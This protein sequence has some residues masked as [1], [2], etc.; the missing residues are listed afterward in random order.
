MLTMT[1]PA[2]DE[3]QSYAGQRSIKRRT[4]IASLYGT[5][6]HVILQTSN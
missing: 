1:C 4:V 5:L 3:V 2:L 6:Y